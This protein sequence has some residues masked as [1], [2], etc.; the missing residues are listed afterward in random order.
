[1]SVK[2]GVPRGEEAAPAAQSRVLLRPYTSGCRRG[3]TPRTRSL[4]RPYFLPSRSCESRP[5]Y[6]IASLPFLPSV[7]FFLPSARN[8][9][10]ALHAMSTAGMVGRVR[11]L[12]VPRTRR[13]AMGAH[14]ARADW[15]AQSSVARRS[16]C[17]SLGT[18]RHERT[19]RRKTE[20]GVLGFT[21]M[22][23]P[24]SGAR[25]KH[26]A[27]ICLPRACYASRT[28]DAC[29]LTSAF[30]PWP[31]RCA[32]SSTTRFSATEVAQG[33]GKVVVMMGEVVLLVFQAF[34]YIFVCTM[35]TGT[36]QLVMLACPCF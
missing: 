7:T 25:H 26:G 28:R 2:Y 10:Q 21:H 16:G 35:A 8:R 19:A 32:R 27:R 22:M 18:G 4:C 23:R 17:S 14:H 29:V 6:G 9:G 5:D 31:C 34:K 33:Q 24:L 36:G 13:P 3:A 11:P 20:V 15:R 1:M 30:A 12:R